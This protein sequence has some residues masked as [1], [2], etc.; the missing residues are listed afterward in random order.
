MND[1]S[2]GAGIPMFSRGSSGKPEVS[3]GLT[4]SARK[5]HSLVLRRMHEPG[6]Q[7]VLAE[8]LNVAE[9]TVSRMKS[10]QLGPMCELFAHL[11][12]KLVNQDDVC[13]D[14]KSFECATHF[15]SRAMANPAIARQL[16]LAQ[17]E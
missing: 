16:I 15:A 2:V 9:S 6:M 12:L 3:T 17:G 4:E 13:V 5:M 11:G 10:D 7:T 8:L 14:A 1:D